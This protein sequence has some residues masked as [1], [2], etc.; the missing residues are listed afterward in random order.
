M[1]TSSSAAPASSRYESGQPDAAPEDDLSKMTIDDVVDN[2]VLGM[3]NEYFADKTT[4]QMALDSTLELDAETAAILPD[5]VDDAV[6]NKVDLASTESG[7]ESINRARRYVRE[8]EGTVTLRFFGYVDVPVNG[9]EII[10]AKASPA[11]E[12]CILAILKGSAFHDARPLNNLVTI[13]GISAERHVGK[14]PTLPLSSKTKVKPFCIEIDKVVP[15]MS[16]AVT[17]GV[18]MAHKSALHDTLHS[19]GVVMPDKDKHEKCV[20]IYW[21]RDEMKLRLAGMMMNK[22]KGV[23][24]AQEFAAK[25]RKYAA[26]IRRFSDQT[27]ATKFVEMTDRTLILHKEGKFTADG[28]VVV[29]EDLDE[30][31]SLINMVFNIEDTPLVVFDNQGRATL[32]KNTWKSFVETVESEAGASITDAAGESGFITLEEALTFDVVDTVLHSHHSYITSAWSNEP[33]GIK[34]VRKT[35]EVVSTRVAPKIHREKIMFS[36]TAVVF[37]QD[38]K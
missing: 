3:R 9:V 28:A 11:S 23:D 24:E 12:E 32:G 13:T 38:P 33:K 36:G 14:A 20:D 1:S 34:P 29:W 16:S 27:A 10:N 31:V 35:P 19:S 15:S 17:I 7:Y 5:F 8:A 22:N 30:I 2:A 37:L 25:M 21:M 18:A 4:K 26:S 6:Q